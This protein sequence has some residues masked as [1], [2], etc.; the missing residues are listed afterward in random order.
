M[1]TFF[2][3]Y[4]Q[5]GCVS[6]QN[7]VIRSQCKEAQELEKKIAKFEEQIAAFTQK[8]R[9]SAPVI[10]NIYE[11]LTRCF[12]V[13]FDIQRFSQFLALSQ[14]DSKN[15]F[16]RCSVIIKNFASYFKMVGSQLSKNSAEIIELRKKK[17]ANMSELNKNIDGYNKVI[18]ELDKKICALPKRNEEGII[19][20]VVCHIATKSESIEELD[21]ELESENAVGVLKN[22]KIS[23]DLSLVYPVH[24]KI[25]TEFGDKGQNGEMIYYLSFETKPSAIVTSPAKG[26]VVFAGNFLTYGN[27]VIISNGEYRIF[28]Y[29][30]ENIYTMTGDVVEIGDYVGKM[31]DANDNVIKMELRKS[32]EALDPR[33]WLLQTLEKGKK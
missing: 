5:E 3:C 16:V 13:L 20:N 25:A 21:A 29:G 19:Q 27:M 6:L 14:R 1:F 15:D 17:R 11:I 32:G 10:K 33:H 7:P 22:T 9:V 24:G 31:K 28:L 4:S 26:L 18:T 30:I 23:T 2:P 12:T 8:E